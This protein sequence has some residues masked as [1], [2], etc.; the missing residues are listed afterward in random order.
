MYTVE[1]IVLDARKHE[2]LR[3]LHRLCFFAE[4]CR[5]FSPLLLDTLAGETTI[6]RH[7][8]QGITISDPSVSGS[9][10]VIDVV[11]LPDAGGKRITLKVSYKGR[12]GTGKQYSF[13]TRCAGRSLHGFSGVDC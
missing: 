7:D 2:H 12:S 13:T 3:H 1:R 10:S 4:H 8:G 11:D 6:G 5:P 9:H